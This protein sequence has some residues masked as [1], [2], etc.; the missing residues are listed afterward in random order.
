M[1]LRGD[2]VGLWWED[3]PE[4]I[5]RQ[6]YSGPRPLPHIPNTDWTMPTEFPS[7]EGQGMI[8]IDVETKDPDLRIRGPGANRDGYICGVAVGTEAGF[9]RY[10]PVAHETGENLD[11]EQVFT[12]LRREL[13]REV[14]KVGANLLYDLAYFD[15]AGIPVTGPFYDVQ[16]AE[17]LLDETKLSYSLQSIATDWLGEGKREN[18]MMAWMLRAFGNENN[19]KGNIYRAPA[20]VVGPYAESDVD[21]PLRIF[22]LQRPELERQG[23]W[24]VFML[25]TRLMPLLLAMWKRG[26]RVDLEKAQQAYEQLAARQVQC[27]DELKRLTGHQPDI[28]AAES[29]RQIF[30]AVGVSY[31]L[32][33]KTQKPSFRKDWLATC[34]HPAGQLIVEARKLD[35][36]KGTF[37]KGYILE[38]NLNG[39]IHTSFHQLRSN[40]GGTV[41][42]RFSSSNPNLQNIPIRDKELGPLCRSIFLPDQDCLWHKKDWSQ[43]EFRLAIH[44]A[45]RLRLRGADT[46]VHQYQTDATTDY[47]AIVAT[48]TGLPRSAA[49]S[50]NFGILYGLGITNLAVYLGVS[51]VEAERMYREYL[52]RVPFV[53]KLRE[54]A[55]EAANRHGEI[56]TLSGRKRRF[57]IWERGGQFFPHRVPGSR[58]AFTH[59]ALNARIQGDAADIMKLAMA[60]AWEAGIFAS[61][62]LGAPH[63]T[64]HDELDGSDPQTAATSEAIGELKNIMETCVTL[65]VPLKADSG[66]GANWGAVK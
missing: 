10:Y 49:K 35:K 59:K 40:E 57:T 44:H 18:A 2:A 27:L 61:D 43:I 36:F 54:A 22:A 17:P 8:A 16:I 26:V 47:H 62:I 31:P 3:I 25:E 33:E 30:D 63:L 4:Y 64:V 34:N 1:K 12:W 55:M 21:L 52:R 42:G 11:K 28:W 32:T 20:S 58:R 15:A 66:A 50:I 45:A 46:V 39:R 51:Q 24:D 48:I 6:S 37:I 29:L 5:G 56:I 14:P 65:L 13:K 41:S 19:L 38:G 53:G 7:L 9:R 23:L 60:Q